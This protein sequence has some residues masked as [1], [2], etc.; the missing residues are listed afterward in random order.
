MPAPL[1]VLRQHLAA[2]PARRHR[3]GESALR[4]DS[5][6][7]QLL[8]RHARKPR[9]GIERCRALRTQPRRIGA[10]LLVVA[11]HHLAVVE[12]QRRPDMKLRVN[13]IRTAGRV[14]R[15]LQQFL[16]LLRQLFLGFVNGE[17]GLDFKGFHEIEILLQFDDFLSGDAPAFDNLDE[18]GAA[19]QALQ[20]EYR[21]L[22]A[23]GRRS[24]QL[25]VGAEDA[26]LCLAALL[27]TVDV[28]LV[29][30]G[31]RS[32]GRR[33]V[34][35]LINAYVAHSE[36]V[37]D[38]AVTAKIG[39]IFEVESVNVRLFGVEVI[40]ADGKMFPEFQMLVIGY[41]V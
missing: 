29:G 11:R 16:I 1:L 39:F 26:H 37:M 5:R 2:R 40:I 27:Q 6:D 18:I 22:A 7:D 25:A 24:H 17:S 3:R 21:L 8:E 36:D 19:V 33:A 13:R 28:A 34:A 4:I 14:A 32:N 10:V 23:Y 12:Q 9:G 35:C 38:D 20:A 30:G 31:I 15:H 41:F